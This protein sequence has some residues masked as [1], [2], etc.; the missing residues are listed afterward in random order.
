MKIHLLT[1][2]L[3]EFKDNSVEVFEFPH[4]FRDFLKI[5]VPLQLLQIGKIDKIKLLENRK[6]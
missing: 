1:F 2:E 3:V 6:S 5:I 4:A